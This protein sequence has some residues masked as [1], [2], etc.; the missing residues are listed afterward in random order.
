M[1]MCWAR[2]KKKGRKAGRC[3]QVRQ[4][5]LQRVSKSIRLLEMRDGGQLRTHL[6][7]VGSFFH[8]WWFPDPGRPQRNRT[9]DEW[10]NVR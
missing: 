10:S 8:A 3:L 6:V 1:E 2:P 9:C 4:E 5:Q 7:I